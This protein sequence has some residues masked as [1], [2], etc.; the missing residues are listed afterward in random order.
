MNARL[1]YAAPFHEVMLG[2]C[3]QCVSVVMNARLQCVAP[4]SMKCC[5]VCVSVYVYMVRECV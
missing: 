4:L 2:V 5:M 3:I 1:L